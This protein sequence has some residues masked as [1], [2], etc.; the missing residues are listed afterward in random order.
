MIK[1]PLI[2]LG[3][4][5]NS[6]SGNSVPN[7]SKGKIPY[8]DIEALERGKIKRYVSEKANV[9]ENDII[10][11]KDGARSGM[12][13]HGTEGR[14]GSTLMVLRIKD[15][16]QV[17]SEYMYLF[18][19]YLTEENGN[20]RKGSTI[21]HI[22]RSELLNSKILVPD[23]STQNIICSEMT[24]Y[25]DK[26]NIIKNTMFRLE[27][28]LQQINFTGKST[29]KMQCKIIQSLTDSALHKKL[30]DIFSRP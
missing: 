4:I 26:V 3:D 9:D 12:V 25:I 29:I 17:L 28:I 10:I 6:F 21:Q 23:L 30:H 20:F 19:L 15:G 16:I 2:K 27:D 11:V 1:A 24:P 5:V 14:L 7:N 22:D 18:L 13:L 8:L